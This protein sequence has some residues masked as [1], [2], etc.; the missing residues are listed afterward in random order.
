M[1]F[2]IQIKAIRM[3]LSIIFLKGLRCSNLNNVD[4]DE[5]P[6][7]YVAFHLGLHCLLKYPFCGS[8]I[9]EHAFWLKITNEIVL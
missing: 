5:V 3:G 1:D 8:R 4:P 9:Q 2:P 6:H 7:N